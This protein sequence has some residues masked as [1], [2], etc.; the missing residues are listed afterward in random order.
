[1]CADSDCTWRVRPLASHAQTL[2]VTPGQS[3]HSRSLILG[4]AQN[5]THTHLLQASDI[6][7]S[8]VVKGWFGRFGGAVGAVPHGVVGFGG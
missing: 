3:N 1:M 2:H 6:E 4:A 8:L 7:A 5:V